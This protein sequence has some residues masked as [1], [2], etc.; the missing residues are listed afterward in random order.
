MNS[1]AKTQNNHFGLRPDLLVCLQRDC[2]CLLDALELLYADRTALSR[3]EVARLYSSL[4]YDGVS[5]KQLNAAVSKVCTGSL[6]SESSIKKHELAQLLPELDRRYFIVQGARWEFAFLDR[7][8]RGEISEKD[9]LFLFK[10]VHGSRFV[11]QSW[12][13]FLEERDHQGS[14]VTWEELELPLCDI[15]DERGNS[16]YVNENVGQPV[17]H[18]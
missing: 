7:Y 18:W 14:K 1:E 6:E 4:R 3:V 12:E 5:S 2:S 15:P 9:A 17:L 11:M 13:T 8:K 10:A 16:A